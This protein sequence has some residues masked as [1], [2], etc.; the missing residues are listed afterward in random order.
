MSLGFKL[1][2]PSVLALS[3]AGACVPDLDSLSAE[4]SATS[5]GGSGG[6]GAV[7]PQG[8][9]NTS[10]A[11]RTNTGGSGVVDT[12]TNGDKDAKESDV[13][14][15]G[16]SKCDRCTKGHKC[17]MN[18]DCVSVFCKAGNC[19]DPTCTDK[20]QNQD[21]TGIDCGGPCLP[22]A[23]DEPCKESRDCE[24]DY[25]QDSVCTDH[26]LSTIKD[27]DE[28]DKNCGGE[29]CGPC[30]DTKNCGEARDCKSL[31]CTNGKC[32][33][34]TCNDGVKN[35]GESEIDCGAP[36]APAKACGLGVHCNS[37][38]DCA[39]WVCSPT[40]AKCIADNVVV[41]PADIIDDF[42]DGDFTV[43]QLGGRNGNWYVYSD[44]T[45]A[46]TLGFDVVGIARGASLK[47]I[48]TKGKDFT[49]WGSGMGVNMQASGTTGYNASAYSGV[50]FWARAAAAQSVLVVFPDVDT[51]P[52]GGLCTSC[53]HHYNK[54]VQ[55]STGWQRFTVNFADLALEG[56]TV[57]QPTAFKPEGLI[58]VQFRFAPGQN[59]ELFIDDLAF[60]K[61]N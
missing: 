26:C 56:G 9:S 33:A 20:V 27:A 36:C 8:G 51:D 28:T 17:T 30:D 1:I 19:T 57:P 59:Y 38:A 7:N 55:V 2:V 32:I 46:G 3:L 44:K 6:S 43:A 40:T 54:A 12:C 37:E 61:P 18:S 16:T 11:G 22:C 49:N 45:P 53:D 58:S 31:I 39:S 10:N 21:E 23:I 15:G 35:Q 34:A 52:T 60:L 42:E 4:Y 13:D 24:S 25:C 29:S 47:G 41:A 50:T 14:C 48:H 5:S